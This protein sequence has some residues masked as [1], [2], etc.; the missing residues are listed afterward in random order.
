MKSHPIA[1]TFP[2]D[3]VLCVDEMPAQTRPLQYSAKTQIPCQ[4]TSYALR[5]RGINIKT[6]TRIV[7]VMLR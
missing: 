7:I 1:S 3:P 2:G 4:V 6:I 5:K